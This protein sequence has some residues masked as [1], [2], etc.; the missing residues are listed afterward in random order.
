MMNKTKLAKFFYPNERILVGTI[1]DIEVNQ[2]LLKDYLIELLNMLRTSESPLILIND[3][4]MARPLNAE[5]RLMVGE[6][7]KKYKDDIE[8]SL[9]AM[10]Y[11]VPNPSMQIV[12]ENIF[13]VKSPPIHYELFTKYEE[14][15]SWCQNQMLS[16]NI[17]F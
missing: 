7:I 11:V 5:Q 8:H 12:L 3:I 10:A 2:Q 16:N 1:S 6:F 4:S 17:S 9:Q 15:L 13:R 14:A